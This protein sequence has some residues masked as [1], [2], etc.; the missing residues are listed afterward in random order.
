MREIFLGI[1][2]ILFIVCFFKAGLCIRAEKQYGLLILGV[3]FFLFGI[4]ILLNFTLI[5]QNDE[6]TEKVKNKCP[7]YEEV[8]NV[9]KLK[10]K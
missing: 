8:S 2:F 9:Y 4:S 7:E 1:I 5:S 6:L 10:N 3:M